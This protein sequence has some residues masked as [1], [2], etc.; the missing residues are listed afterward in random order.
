MDSSDS[1]TMVDPYAKTIDDLPDEVIEF[2]LGFLPPYKDLQD[3]MC[4]SKKWYISSKS[5][6]LHRQ[7]ILNLLYE[8]IILLFL[9]DFPTHALITKYFVHRCHAKSIE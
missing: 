6:I 7:F 5:K 4:V 9:S 2:I 8:Q 1:S 3:C